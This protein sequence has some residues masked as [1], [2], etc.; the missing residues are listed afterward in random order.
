MNVQ[1]LRCVSLEKHGMCCG[2]KNAYCIF[3]NTYIIVLVFGAYHMS[4]MIV[5]KKDSHLGIIYFSAVNN[6]RMMPEIRD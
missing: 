6:L 4:S 5:F 3:G 1:N 2:S